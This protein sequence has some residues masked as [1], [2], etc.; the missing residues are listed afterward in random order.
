M[1]YHQYSG[2][3]LNKVNFHFARSV[4]ITALQKSVSIISLTLLV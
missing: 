2:I 1:V 4:T 3:H